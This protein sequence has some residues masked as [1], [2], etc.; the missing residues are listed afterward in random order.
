MA[1]Q[2]KTVKM[3]CEKCECDQCCAHIPESSAATPEGSDYVR[4]FCD[5]ACYDRWLAQQ[6]QTKEGE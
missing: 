3:G 5:Q 4:Q 6:K 2:D 1:D